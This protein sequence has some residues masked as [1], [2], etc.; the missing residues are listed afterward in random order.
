MEENT[1]QENL[2]LLSSQNDEEGFCFQ[3]MEEENFIQNIS[4]NDEKEIYSKNRSEENIIQEIYNPPES[5]NDGA[6]IDYS[7]IQN[8]ETNQNRQEKNLVLN[9]QNES[10]NILILNSSENRALTSNSTA[11]FRNNQI[12]LITPYI[13]KKRLRKVFKARKKKRSLLYKEKK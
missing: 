2:N 8:I 11:S 3:E 10:P 13:G 6:K 5:Q 12:K 1:I 9:H 4:Q 7:I